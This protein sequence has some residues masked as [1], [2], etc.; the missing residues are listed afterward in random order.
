[1]ETEI[2]GFG[3]EEHLRAVRKP[4]DTEPQGPEA[5]T[6]LALLFNRG[7][8][9]RPAGERAG[10]QRL[11]LS[12]V[13]SLLIWPCSLPHILPPAGSPLCNLPRGCGG[14]GGCGVWA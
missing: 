11:P 3:A 9:W 12:S 13:R 6:S 8:T 10:L 14:C 7:S 5:H 4:L 2:W 1:M